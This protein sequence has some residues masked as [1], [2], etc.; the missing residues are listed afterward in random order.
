MAMVLACCIGQR[1]VISV[2]RNTLGHVRYQKIFMICPGLFS[3]MTAV[4]VLATPRQLWHAVQVDV[5]CFCIN[6]GGL[7]LRGWGWKLTSV[8]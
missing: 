4:A 7:R 2:V 1:V 8:L 3:P 6:T 5:V